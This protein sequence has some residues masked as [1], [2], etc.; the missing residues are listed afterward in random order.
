MEPKLYKI[1]DKEYTLKQLSEKYNIPE[2]TL[3]NRFVKRK[4]MQQ[5]VPP[6][7][8]PDRSKKY[9]RN[10][11]VEYP[12]NIIMELISDIHDKLD[13]NYIITNFD[14]NLD[15]FVK[16]NP[17]YFSERDLAI[18]RLF[19]KENLTY[20][21]C[22]NQL[23]ITKQRVEQLMILIMEKLKCSYVSD[24]YLLGPE[25]IKERDAYFERRKQEFIN[26]VDVTFNL[27]KEL[28]DKN[29]D[30]KPLLISKNLTVELSI[31]KL[32]LEKNIE[33]RLIQGNI[34]TL[35]EL[36]KLRIADI[37]KRTHLTNASIDKIK[38]AIL[39]FTERA[40]FYV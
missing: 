3:Y 5:C 21:E 26:N 10:G 40:K 33:R 20:Q 13:L 23:G 27:Y 36:L 12:E 1:D 34:T 6:Y 18:I 8:A 32:K 28:S 30:N 31:T 19:Y 2:R 14:S 35:N 37:K 9:I 4:D 17:E 16:E 39:D 22:G 25:W 7:Y 29:R 24:Y 11:G 15:F 38:K